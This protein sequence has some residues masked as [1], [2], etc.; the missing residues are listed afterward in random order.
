MARRAMEQAIEQIGFFGGVQIP[1][2]T[3]TQP[4]KNAPA[5]QS[6]TDNLQMYGMTNF[7]GLTVGTTANDWT[8]PATAV[9]TIVD[10]W[11]T[12]INAIRTN[13]KGIHNANCVV[14]P[15]SI[16]T[17]LNSRPRSVTFTD[18][19]LLTYLLRLQPSIKNVYWTPMLE[20]AGKKQDTV[21]AG[22]RIML[23]ERNA[24]NMQLVLP[25]GFEQLPPQMINLTFKVPCH[26][27]VAGVRVSYPQAFRALDGA[28][29]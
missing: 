10:D 4:I 22:P 19:N 13:S 16:W 17:V 20:T 15:L 26:Q 7:P 2:I 14:F 3:G 8:S 9:G 23:F 28:A 18:D 5:T 24:E 1:G 21:T 11:N 25:G 27:R 12:N 6:T 29:G